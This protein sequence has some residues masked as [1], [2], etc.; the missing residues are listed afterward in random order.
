MSQI[1]SLAKDI[2]IKIPFGLRLWQILRS[3]SLL[4]DKSFRALFF[5]VNKK[6]I[7]LDIGANFG[8]ASLIMWLKGAKIIYALEPN[9]EA[10]NLLNYNL[11]NIKNIYSFNIAIS[12][13]TE[14]Q[15]LYLHKSID[16]KSSDKEILKYS[17]ASS[18]ISQKTNIGD[19]F[20]EVNAINFKDLYSK[21]KFKPT[22]IKCDI[23]GGEYIIYEQLI[24]LARSSEIKKIFVECHAKKYPE[25]NKSHKNFIDLINKYN[26]NKIIDISWH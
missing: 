2:L 11:S 26:L 16:K 20:Y 10:Y 25:F 12:S 17:Q 23:E 3:I 22:L 9:K 5:E 1:K 13:N 14:K 15:K 4:K 7:C 18:L 6:D 8:H 19:C 24:E 21:L